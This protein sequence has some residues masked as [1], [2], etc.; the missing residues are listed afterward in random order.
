MPMVKRT[1]NP[2]VKHVIRQLSAVN[3]P[4]GSGM[5][6]ATP[7]KVDAE[8]GNMLLQGYRIVSTHYLGKQTDPSNGAEY[9]GVM[10]I[11]QLEQSEIERMRQ[12]FVSSVENLTGRD[13]KAE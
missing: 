11:L 10:Y 4:P 5:G 13:S 3:P 6:Y 9:F 2:A 7:D 12:N 8:V 1:L